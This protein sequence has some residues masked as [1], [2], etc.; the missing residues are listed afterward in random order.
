MVTTVPE[1]DDL[2][3]TM[4]DASINDRK[5]MKALFAVVAGSLLNQ[6]WASLSAMPRSTNPALMPCS[7]R[8]AEQFRVILLLQGRK[9]GRGVVHEALFVVLSGNVQFYDHHAR[10]LYKTVGHGTVTGG[11]YRVFYYVTYLASRG[12]GTRLLEEMKTG[13]SSIL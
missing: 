6:V 5:S 9:S 8:L 2:V 1:N 3:L 10:R 11:G 13:V 4:M 7:S 12:H